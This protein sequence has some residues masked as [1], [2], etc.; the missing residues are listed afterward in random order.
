MTKV[1]WP[2]FNEN[3]DLPPGIYPATLPEIIAHF[4][5]RPAKRRVLAQ[6]LERLYRLV[7]ETNHLRRFIV[8]GSFVSN[9][10]EPGDIDIFILMQDS[11]D[12]GQ[13]TGE[14]R[15]AFDHFTAQN[16]EG[17]SV[18]WLRLLAVLDSEEE[19]IAYWQ[20]KRD[21]TFRG[22]VEVISDDQE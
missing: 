6:R 2:E 10:S 20:I 16:Y 11:F 19:T 12:A 17:A 7:K 21:G 4:G 15:L 14:A 8:F 1:M 5:Q 22:I 9:K 18:F 3:G 13:L